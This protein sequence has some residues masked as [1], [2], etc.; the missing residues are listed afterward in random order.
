MRLAQEIGKW[1]TYGLSEIYLLAARSALNLANYPRES[2]CYR[3]AK[4]GAKN[5]E[6]GTYC[7]GVGYPGRNLRGS[8]KPH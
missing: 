5:R 6:Q 1:G 2:R 8:G 4:V 7:C 3:R